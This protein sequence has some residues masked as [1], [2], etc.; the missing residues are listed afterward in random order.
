MFHINSKGDVLQSS[1][2]LKLSQLFIAICDGADP[3]RNLIK[4]QRSVYRS[5]IRYRYDISDTVLKN[6]PS[7]IRSLTVF[8]FLR[9]LDVMG[10]IITCQFVMK[11]FFYYY[12]YKLY[13][14]FRDRYLH[15][16]AEV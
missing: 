1:P 11:F 10:T 4:C 8:S 15:V 12:K 16:V 5:I 2:L 6:S 7:N 9:F 3:R 14:C 13:A